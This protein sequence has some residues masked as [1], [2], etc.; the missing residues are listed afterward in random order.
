MLLCIISHHSK[1][2]ISIFKHQFSNHHL[3]QD[4]N[5]HIHQMHIHNNLCICNSN[6]LQLFKLTQRLECS[7]S[8]LQCL[9]NHQHSNKCSQLLFLFH[10]FTHIL[11]IKHHHY[12]SLLR[13]HNS[14]NQYR[15]QHN[16]AHLNIISLIRLLHINKMFHITNHPKWHSR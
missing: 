3:S 11:Q 13:R 2:L 7:L 9:H 5:F 14:N 8:I 15:H 4:S 6:H 16:R 10:L 1:H 12:H